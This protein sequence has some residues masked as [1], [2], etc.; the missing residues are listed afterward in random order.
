MTPTTVHSDVV[1]AIMNAGYHVEL[2]GGGYLNA[3]AMEEA[4]IR[5]VD[6]V[7]P[8]RGVTCNLIYSSPKAIGW[9]VPMIGRL[10]KQGVPIDGITIGA[11]VPSAEVITEYVTNLG[12]KHVA[13]KPGSIATIKQVIEAAKLHPTFP[14]ILQWTGGRGGGHHS[15]EDFHAPILRMYGEIRR[16]PNIILVAGSGFGDAQGIQPYFSGNWAHHFGR[17]AMPFD[18]V[19]LGSRM[20]VAKEAHTSRATKDVI[21]ATAGGSDWERSYS[22][23]VGGSARSRQKWGSRYTR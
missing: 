20:M 14:I 13:F 6:A 22:G 4:I 5:V 9:Q 3:G 12:L 8:G 15:F 21:V 18:G 17:P 2:A 10:I 23:T 11:G 7:T 16:C 19:L 1:S